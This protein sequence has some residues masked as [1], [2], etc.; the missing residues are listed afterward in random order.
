ME[1]DAIFLKQLLHKY[2]TVLTK[3]RELLVKKIAH[4]ILREVNV[5]HLNDFESLAHNQLKNIFFVR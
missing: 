1:N 2:Y 3:S 4:I 5:L